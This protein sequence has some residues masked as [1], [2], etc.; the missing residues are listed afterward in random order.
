MSSSLKVYHDQHPVGSLSVNLQGQMNFQYAEEWMRASFGFPISLSLPFQKNTFEEKK[1]RPFFA[2][3]LPEGDV[4]H[5]IARRFGISPQNDFK[6]LEAIGGDC[7][8]ALSLLPEENPIE[9]K[10]DYKPLSLEQ[11]D[12]SIEGMPLETLL[13]EDKNLRLSLAGVQQK[14]PVYREKDLFFLPYGRAASTHILKPAISSI[15]E[16]VLNEFF[17][18]KLAAKLELPVPQVDIISTPRHSVFCVARY[19]RRVVATRKVVRLHQEDFCQALSL[20]PGLKYQNE[21]GPNLENI[22]EIIEKYSSKPALD[23]KSLL[24]WIIFN[25]LIGNY[26]AHGKNIS[27]LISTDQ[28]V[29][30]PFYDLMSTAVYDHLS[31]KMAMKIGGEYDPD[32]IFERH[33]ERLGEAMRVKKNFI[34]KFLADMK[35]KI[36]TESVELADDFKKSEIIKKIIL[37]IQKKTENP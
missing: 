20:N 25:F 17:C 19:D 31:Q 29:L 7:A 37:H 21:G 15:E 35:K 36:R 5:L 23:K 22:I 13:L 1:T 2:N 10:E 6:M 28:V 4:R 24:E 3:L 32:K 11:L 26:D 33:W 27:L 14:L 16:S 12:K 18:M 34:L 9:E 8:G 30:A